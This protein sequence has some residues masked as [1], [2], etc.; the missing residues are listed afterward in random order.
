MLLEYNEAG[1]FCE[2]LA[3][4]MILTHKS[5]AAKGFSTGGS[6]PYGHVRALFNPDGKLVEIL[7]QGRTVRQEGYHVRWIPGDDEENRAKIKTWIYIL[8]EYTAGRGAK[9]IANQLNRAG[10]PSPGGMGPC[11]RTVE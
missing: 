4:R 3:E 1:T 6:P 5:L 8:E 2:Q 7:T 9:R 11:G 10:I